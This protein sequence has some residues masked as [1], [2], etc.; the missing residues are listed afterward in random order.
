MV[1]KANGLD[2]SLKVIWNNII[3]NNNLR[4]NLRNDLRNYVNTFKKYFSF[5][6]LIIK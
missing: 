1:L 3:Q 2:P 6:G 5:L 4:N